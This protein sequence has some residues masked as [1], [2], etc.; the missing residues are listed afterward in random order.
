MGQGGKKALSFT[1]ERGIIK[2]KENA[3]ENHY[4]KGL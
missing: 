3:N 1:W 4:R 2:N